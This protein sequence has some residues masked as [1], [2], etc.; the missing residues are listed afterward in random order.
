V[1]R[2][3]DDPVALA[4]LSTTWLDDDQRERCL[5]SLLEDGLAVTTESGDV[6]LPH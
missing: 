6:A 2:S 3:S 4:E 5:A 1:L